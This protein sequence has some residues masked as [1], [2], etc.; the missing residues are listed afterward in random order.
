MVR[1]EFGPPVFGCLVVAALLA[2]AGLARAESERVLVND[3]RTAA[4]TASVDSLRV[5]L[6]AREGEWRP[7]GDRTPGLRVKAF[8]VRG[9]AL[10]VPG[11]LIRVREGTDVHVSVTNRT[12]DALTIHGLYTRPA[13]A[14]AVPFVVGAG[15]TREARFVAGTAGTYYYWAAA[16]PKATITTRN[17]LDSQL[18][19]AFVVDPRGG[20]PARD[21]VL[22]ITGWT[23]GRVFGQPGYIFRY[24]ING[25]SWPQTERL[26]YRVGDVVR[27]R[28][29][30][31]GNGVH[32]MHLHGFYFNVD[33]RGDERAHALLPADAPPRLVVTERM[34]SG[35]TFALTWTPTRPGNW[36]FHCHDTAHI[37]HGGPLGTAPA[38]IEEATH[39]HVKN[40]ALEMMAGPVMGITV[41]GAS[42]EAAEPAGTRRQLRLVARVGAD[43]T[44]AEPAFSYALEEGGRAPAPL[45]SVGPTILL[46]RGEP[47]SISVVNELPEATSVHWHGIELESYFDGVPGYAGT[48][49]RLA[50]VIAPGSTFEARFTPPRSGTFM[51]HSH[52]DE[53]RQ[54]QAGLTGALLVVDDPAAF[55]PVHDHVL[56][57]TVPRKAADSGVVLL[58]GSS[59]PAPLHMKVGDTYR[60]RF[61]NLHTFRPAMRMRL[62]E[63]TTLA[64]WRS[65][66]KDGMDLPAARRTEGA[67][68]IQMG[69]GEAYD[70]E[71]VPARAGALHV[72]VTNAAG[73]LLVTMPVTVSDSHR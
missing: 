8:A 40:H 55:D 64:S 36:L 15:E 16:D 48:G 1:R 12:A 21:R 38:P 35:S 52:V 51:Y 44:D 62:L 57:V 10:Q 33:G 50:P 7:D 32:P 19:G 45:A 2:G 73:Q 53:L 59:T 30:N 23:N 34:A 47:I 60:L 4:G 70:F 31:V 42:V 71:F 14:D 25:R 18:S 46:K 13:T 6:D 68:E 28:L 37:V 39:R 29:V 69:N 56:V 72:D 43:G 65:V 54:Q 66:A 58:N 63:G 67:A 26:A 9:Q 41:T 5:V 49:K 27:L 61:I 20:P 22:V 11:P 17:P 24:A 3:N